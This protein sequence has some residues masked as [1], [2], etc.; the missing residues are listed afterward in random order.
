MTVTD[1]V[2][3]TYL[4]NQNDEIDL[5]PAKNFTFVWSVFENFSKNHIFSGHTMINQEFINWAKALNL[6]SLPTTIKESN[7]NKEIDREHIQNID[8]AFNHFYQKFTADTHAFITVLYNQEIIQVEREKDKFIEFKNDLDDKNVIDEIIF[9]YFISK[10]MR[11]KF[12]HRIKSIVDVSKDKKE[13]NKINEYL[14]AIIGLI[15]DY[16]D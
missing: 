15:E 6:D 14:M 13:F 9:L 3:D 10:R 8:K 16:E 12:F 5:E 1:W 11:N 2:M 4:N 7:L